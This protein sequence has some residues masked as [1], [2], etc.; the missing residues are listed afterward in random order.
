M[1]EMDDRAYQERRAR[2]RRRG[3]LGIIIK[4]ILSIVICS[5]LIFFAVWTGAKLMFPVASE[6]TGLK[7]ELARKAG[8]DKLATVT[9]T[10]PEGR[11][12]ELQR[13][14][15]KTGKWEETKSLKLSGKDRQ[16]VK[17][18]FPK[19]WD[20]ATYSRWRLFM[21]GSFGI[22][23]YVGDPVDVIC[24]NRGGLKLKAAAA[25]VY[26]VEDKQVL[27]DINMHKKLPNAS[28][29]KM[30]TA[31]LALENSKDSDV[32][33]VSRRAAITYYSSFPFR[34]G[35]KFYMGDLLRAMLIVSSNESASAVAEYV[36]GSY[37][38]FAKIMNK[39]A[40]ELG[41]KHTNFVTPSGLDA[42]GHHSTAYDLAMI[43]AE[44][45]KSDEYNKIML[46]KK[47]KF[48]CVNK[49]N[50]KFEAKATN[51]LLKEKIKGYMG[52]K[53]GTT[54]QAGNCLS[55]AYKWKGKEYIIVVLDAG[56]RF[57]ATKKLMKYVRKYS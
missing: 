21:K 48:R 46:M 20:D 17:I 33:P 31:I 38:A 39:R 25:C 55:S 19:G 9:V 10:N 56:D 47:H 42:K 40:K 27:Y 57:E 35:Y 32:V 54:P 49:K 24:R 12:L 30:I 4:V 18:T 45:I 15:K 1:D 16:K 26:S 8:N 13:F 36:G 2:R 50:E 7:T 28:T 23:K 41:A 5:P 43:N 37:E 14:D 53:T 6:V 34:K 44:A 11:E 29:T 51:D 3:V 22:K 52:G